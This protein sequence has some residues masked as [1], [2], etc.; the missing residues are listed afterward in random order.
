MLKAT[1]KLNVVEDYKKKEK[2][3]T[4]HW[5]QLTDFVSEKKKI[6]VK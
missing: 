1:R 4:E 2:K 5:P 6:L 3:K